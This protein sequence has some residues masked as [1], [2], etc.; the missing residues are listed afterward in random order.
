MLFACSAESHAIPAQHTSRPPCQWPQTLVV[1]CVASLDN[2]PQMSLT[3]QLLSLHMLLPADVVGEAAFSTKMG[4]L[5]VVQQQDGG[6]KF[7]PH[8]YLQV[9]RPLPHVPKPSVQPNPCIL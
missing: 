4:A 5:E 8:A 1:C 9:Q 2:M 3:G 6:Y 7:V